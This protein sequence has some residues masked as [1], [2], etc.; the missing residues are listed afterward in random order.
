MQKLSDEE[1]ADL[2]ITADGFTPKE[3]KVEA[4]EVRFQENVLFL[5]FFCLKAAK[6]VCCYLK[7]RP[8]DQ[9]EQLIG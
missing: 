6:N 2:S 8:Y 4:H 3:T 9:F 1:K 5:V 7:P